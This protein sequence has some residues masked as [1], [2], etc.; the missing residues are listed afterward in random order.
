MAKKLNLILELRGTVWK[1]LLEYS[2]LSRDKRELVFIKKREEYDKMREFYKIETESAYISE[3][4][5]KTFKV[6]EADVYRT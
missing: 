2:P 3:K 4:E 5:R 1:I 6:I